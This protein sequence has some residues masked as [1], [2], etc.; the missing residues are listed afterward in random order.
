MRRR[1]TGTT[2][3]FEGQACSADHGATV[4]LQSMRHF[5]F[6]SPGLLAGPSHTCKILFCIDLRESSPEVDRNGGPM[7]RQLHILTVSSARLCTSALRGIHIPS[8]R[9][10]NK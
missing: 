9:G 6:E 3:F 7:A 10:E 5:G 1:L 8:L 4:A 2:S